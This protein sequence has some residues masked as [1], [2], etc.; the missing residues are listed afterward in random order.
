MLDS[1]V[2][3]RTRQLIRA[4]EE[5]PD[6]RALSIRRLVS[7]AGDLRGGA[8]LTID[9]DAAEELGHPL[10]VLYELEF[11]SQSVFDSLTARE[12]E[13]AACVGAEGLSNEQ[14]ASRLCL[15]T[16]TVKD[17][18]HSILTKTGLSNR[19]AIAVAWRG[20]PFKER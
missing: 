14:I 10:V 20:R 12:R 9:F 5:A 16:A 3:R 17:H 8:S 13:V 4:V 11:G 6:A 19:T 18:V 2:L 1:I 7:I 15:T